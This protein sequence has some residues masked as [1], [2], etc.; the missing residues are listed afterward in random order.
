MPNYHINNKTGNIAR[1]QATKRPCHFAQHFYATGMLDAMTQRDVSEAKTEL[2]KAQEKV[3]V[4]KEATPDGKE[5]TEEYDTAVKEMWQAEVDYYSWPAPLKNLKEMIASYEQRR[6]FLLA[7]PQSSAE[8]FEV[9]S[10]LETY[11]DILYNVN[12]TKK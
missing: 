1:C 2:Q 5:T 7:N 6:Q 9:S 8:V 10:K 4:L 3:R 11:K 12:N